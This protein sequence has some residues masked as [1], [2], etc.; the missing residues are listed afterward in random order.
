[1]G[2]RTDNNAAVSFSFVSRPPAWFMM[3]RVAGNLRH[4]C[5]IPNLTGEQGARAM[6][7][8]ARSQRT[9]WAQ[10]PQMKS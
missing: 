5:W 6:S 2:I 8:D 3:A 10:Q 1:M 7:W 4:G 9:F